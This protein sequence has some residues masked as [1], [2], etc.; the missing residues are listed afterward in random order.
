[1]P[2][3]QSLAIRQPYGGPRTPTGGEILEISSESLRLITTFQRL[4]THRRLLL[5]GNNIFH[6][7][8]GR[9]KLQAL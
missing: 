4:Q 1:M 9:T 2:S 8:A 6:I 7:Y 3:S 5:R